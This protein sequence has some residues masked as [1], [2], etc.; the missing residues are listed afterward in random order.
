MEFTLTFSFF[1]KNKRSVCC[2]V[3]FVSFF[4]LQKS[5]FLYFIAVC[6][7]ALRHNSNHNNEP[8]RDNFFPSVLFYQICYEELYG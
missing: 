1:M 6:Y 2:C 3:G 7:I 5:F 4:T 8:Q